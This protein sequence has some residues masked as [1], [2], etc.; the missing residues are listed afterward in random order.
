M[1]YEHYKALYPWCLSFR[2]ILLSEV[3]IQAFADLS[4]L[5]IA[6][7]AENTESSVLLVFV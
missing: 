5:I 7:A 4:G 6:F 1:R 2:V 3:L